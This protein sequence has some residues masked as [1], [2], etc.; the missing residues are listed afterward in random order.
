MRPI[1]FLTTILALATTVDARE[2]SGVKM[3]DT[4]VV[5]NK[6]L[7]LNGMGLREATILKVNVYVAGLYVEHPSSNPAALL[8]E[9]ESKRLVLVFVRDVDRKDI[10]KAWTEGFKNNATVPLAQIK[11]STDRLNA[12]MP[13]FKKGDTLAFTYVP[14]RGVA[15]DINGARKGIIEGEDFAHSLYSIWLGPKPPTGALKRGLLGN[16]PK[17]TS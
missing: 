4:V 6:Q 7:V 10:T 8:T 12:W 14:G 15:V 17:S 1:I 2:K 16:H 13:E 3:P 5:A 11:P 9:N